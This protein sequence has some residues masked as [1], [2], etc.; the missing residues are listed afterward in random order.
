M[1]QIYG[2]LFAEVEG[3]FVLRIDGEIGRHR[4]L[5]QPL[6]QGMNQSSTQEETRV[7]QRVMEGGWIQVEG[8]VMNDGRRLVV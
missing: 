7:E 3:Q 5:S 1:A 8:K 6:I 4:P 2:Q